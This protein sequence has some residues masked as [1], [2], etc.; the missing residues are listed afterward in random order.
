MKNS[1]KY[2]CSA[3][4]YIEEIEYDTKEEKI[5][6]LPPD[7]VCPNCKSNRDMFISCTCVKYSQESPRNLNLEEMSIGDIVSTYPQSTQVFNKH[8]IDYCCGGKK[9][10]GEVC[11]KNGL[12]I[13]SIID[14]INKSVSDNKVINVDWDKMTL[15]SLIDHIVNYYHKRLFNDLKELDPLMAKVLKVHGKRHPELHKISQVLAKFR[16]DAE[17]HML[18]EESILFPA[19]QALEVSGKFNAC[20]GNINYP[21]AVMEDEHE[22]MAKQI[23]AIKEFSHNY[24]TPS[25]ACG[26]YVRL[27]NKFKDIEIELHEHVHKEN[28]I[29]FKK[30]LNKVS[31]NLNLI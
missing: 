8:D 2:V 24:A 5:N 20:S 14:E 29:L 7:F 17:I 15:G 21:I 10:L 26:S 1:Q 4:D 25:D 13:Q 12:P 27:Y 11:L 3:C 30:S 6:L 16:Q 22:R 28:N 9:T 18:K 23:E 19:I 31:L